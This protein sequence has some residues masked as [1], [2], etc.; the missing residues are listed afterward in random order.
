MTDISII[1]PV[2]NEA[3]ALADFL[4]QFI[5]WRQCGDEVIVVDGG[6][7]DASRT[8]AEPHCDQLIT[9]PRGR[10]TQ[11]NAGTQIAHGR[12][13]WFVHAD[14]KISPLARNALLAACAREIAWGRFDVGIEDQRLVFRTIESS[15]NMRSRITAIATGDQGI[16]VRRELFDAIGGFPDIALMEDIELSRSL[17]ARA[18]PHCLG[19]L[20]TTSSRRWREHGVLKTIVT[21]WSLRLA[22]FAGVSPQRL[23]RIYGYR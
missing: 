23:A 8:V 17:R 19:P 21:M 1:V 12:I 3:A 22:W 7:G 2:L 9:A 6:S 16:F 20:L 18:K 11:L 14:T 10:A 4:E 13:L 5:T 15:M